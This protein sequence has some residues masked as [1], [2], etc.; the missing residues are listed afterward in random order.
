MSSADRIIFNNKTK[1]AFYGYIYLM[2]PWWSGNIKT[3]DNGR[4]WFKDNIDFRVNSW[5]VDSSYCWLASTDNGIYRSC[6]NGINWKKLDTSGLIGI[7]LGAIGVSPDGYIYGFGVGGLF[8]NKM[9]TSV[10]DARNDSTKINIVI[11]KNT[12]LK[13]LI[14]PKFP[15]AKI[16]LYSI[17]GEKILDRDFID[18]LDVS[19]L[20]IGVYFLKIEDKVFKF[21]KN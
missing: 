10:S 17:T 1:S 9:I 8:T 19:F 12:E 20:Q 18:R 6:D 14:K 21:L 4:T 3:T 13:I 15:N 11:S 16:Q 2:E 5:A 7:S